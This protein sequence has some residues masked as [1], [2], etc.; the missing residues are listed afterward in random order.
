LGWTLKPAKTR[1]SK[2]WTEA[3]YT[4]FIRSA[5]RGAFR[6][7]PP[8]YDV[9]RNAFTEARLNPKTGR[10]AKHYRCAEC[11]KDFPQKGVQVDHKHPVVDTKKGFVDWNTFIERLLVEAKKLQ[12]LCKGCH[13][14]KT[15]AER[16]KRGAFGKTG[17]RKGVAS[18]EP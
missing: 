11:G 18:S 1:N 14:S 17:V 2:R 15:K 16:M 13:T 7:W 6:R 9:L 3:R 12:V 10:V 4:Q 5:L 8:R